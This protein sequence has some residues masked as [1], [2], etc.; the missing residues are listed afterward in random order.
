MSDLNLADYGD[1]IT[2]YK[3]GSKIELT[4]DEITQFKRF[5][6]IRRTDWMLMGVLK[7]EC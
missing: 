6:D 7:S 5:L 1:T 4:P 2:L 3:N